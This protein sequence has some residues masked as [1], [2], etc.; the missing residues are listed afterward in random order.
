MRIIDELHFNECIRRMRLDTGEDLET[1]GMSGETKNL[2]LCVSGS[3]DNT[4]QLQI[5]QCLVRD[6][7]GDWVDA[8]PTVPQWS[9]LDNML[10]REVHLIYGVKSD[11][12]IDEDRAR[13]EAEDLHKYGHPGAIYSKYY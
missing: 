11:A 7:R 12:Q 10:K 4:Y 13:Q 8:R 2:I 3:Q 5:D 1:I 9:I 6:N